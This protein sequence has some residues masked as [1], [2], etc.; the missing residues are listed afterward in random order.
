MEPKF[1]TMNYCESQ[2]SSVFT[3]VYVLMP[4]SRWSSFRLWEY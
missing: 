3:V 2:P 1:Y 4:T